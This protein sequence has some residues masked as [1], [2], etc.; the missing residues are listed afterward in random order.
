M[1]LV[2]RPVQSSFGECMKLCKREDG[3]WIVEMPSDCEECG[4]YASED[5]AEDDRVGL[6]ESF[7]NWYDLDF[8]LGEWSARDWRA[9]RQDYM[10]EQLAELK[11]Q[12]AELLDELT[13]W[14]KRARDAGT[15]VIN[16]RLYL[17]TA[18]N[19]DDPKSMIQHA[20]QTCEELVERAN[21]ARDS[22]DHDF[23]SFLDLQL[24]SFA[25]T[26]ANLLPFLEQ[27]DNETE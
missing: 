9:E 5:E 4:P 15:N 2:E 14:R 12:A 10:K 16:A 22:G 3:W 21:Q 19:S 8:T 27:P 23:A 11:S 25:G 17:R 1:N 20:K 6:Q 26:V 7:D 18:V 24:N 13:K